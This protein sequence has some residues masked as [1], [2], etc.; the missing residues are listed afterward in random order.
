[1]HPADNFIAKMKMIRLRLDSIKKRQKEHFRQFK[2]L[3]KRN[4][5]LK[6]LINVLNTISVTSLVLSFSVSSITL[7]VCAA[8]NSLSAVGTAVLSVVDMDAKVHSH[9]T[10]YLQ[11]V[12]LHDT[13]IAQLLHDNLTGSELDRILI[14]I[15]AKVSLILDNCE[16]IE[17]SS[18]NS[19]GIDEHML[20]G[21]NNMFNQSPNVQYRQ[22]PYKDDYITTSVKYPKIIPVFHAPN[23]DIVPSPTSNDVVLSL[24]DTTSNDIVLTISGTTTV[25][26]QLFPPTSTL[27]SQYG[28]STCP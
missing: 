23:D 21:R 2:R 14:D 11:F 10:S 8:S 28:E 6:A 25:L 1:M 3:K 5:Y 7:F 26:E 22:T 15:N 16:P 4:T 9:Q 24:P 18:N 20:T 13:Y 17:L 12:D 19:T 27:I